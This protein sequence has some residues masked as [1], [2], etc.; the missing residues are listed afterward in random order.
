MSQR[1]LGGFITNNPVQPTQLAAPGSWTLQQQFQAQFG[2]RWPAVPPEDPNFEYVTLL[3]NGDGTNGAQNN[4]FLDSSSNNFSITRNGNTTQ[5]SFSPYG[6]L[7]SNYFG[8]SGNHLTATATSAFNFTGNWTMECWANISDAGRTAD[9]VKYGTFFSCGTQLSIPNSWSLYF[10]ISGGVITELAFDV[11]STFFRPTVSI[12]LNTWFHIACVRNG[13]TV[14]IYLNG[15]SVGTTT[16]SGTINGSGN[17]WVGRTSYGDAYVN[18]MQG[19]LSSVRINNTA[20]LYTSNFTPSTT[21]LTAVSG[22]S[23]LTSQSNRFIDNSTNNATI[24]VTGTPSVQRFSPF[25]PTAPY[26]TSVIGG[27]GYFD[28]TGDYLNLSTGT[29]LSLTG[30]FTI[31]AFVYQSASASF[32]GIFS[33]GDFPGSA[34]ALL[35]VD[36][37]IPIFRIATGSAWGLELPA[38]SAIP[39]NTWTHIAITCSGSNFTLWVNGSSAATATYSGARATPNATSAIGRF[40]VSTNNFYFNGNISNLRVVKG[41]AVYTSAFTPP[42][43]P[44]TAITNTS[45]LLLYTNA[46][47]PDLAMMN[48]LETGGNAQVS[49]SVKKYGTGSLAFDGTGD[50]LISNPPTTDLYAFGTGAFT[51]EFWLYLNATQTSIMYDSRPNLANGAYPTIYVDSNSIRY[52]TN[53]SIVITGATLS[54][55]T[56][57]HIALCRSGTSTKLFVDGTQSGSTYTDSTV[58]LNAAQRP[59]FGTDGYSINT[60][61][62]NGYIDD[63]RVTKGVARYTTT[64]TPPAAALPIY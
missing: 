59:I 58:Y 31:E 41:T 2:T 34:Q 42:T 10:L 14:T 64:F 25:E 54:N 37:G 1:Y 19:Y 60:N 46:G 43:A 7:W 23:M 33:N 6:N 36:A 3:L 53:T 15:T 48:N 38:P 61:N 21:P 45:L 22:T 50:W 35:S 30:D 28:G 9:A 16:I 27:S 11:G 20:A 63:L 39:L 32:Q 24:T 5:G 8:G 51:I 56:W 44:L 26:S 29:A 18:W 52:Y 12:P 4:T 47:I 49:T 17:F 57:Y 62:L 40:Y 13:T 55:S